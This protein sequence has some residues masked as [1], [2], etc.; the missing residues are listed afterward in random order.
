MMLDCR[1]Y[2]DMDQTDTKANTESSESGGT[3]A[4]VQDTPLAKSQLPRRPPGTASIVRSLRPISSAL[5][6]RRQCGLRGLRLGDALSWVVH[7]RGSLG[8]LRLPLLL[9]LLST[10]IAARCFAGFGWA[11]SPAF[12]GRF[13]GLC[14]LHVLCGTELNLNMLR[15]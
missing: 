6:T 9:L 8:L 5:T 2:Y 1:S 4:G 13:W 3:A 14:T 7:L 11:P 10:N 15:R 12:F